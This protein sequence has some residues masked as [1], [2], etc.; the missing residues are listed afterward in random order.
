MLWF[1]LTHVTVRLGK[2][3]CDCCQLPVLLLPLTCD[4]WPIL[5]TSNKG[6]KG[7]NTPGSYSRSPWDVAQG[8][9]SAPG[10]LV[11]QQLQGS[12]GCQACLAATRQQLAGQSVFL[13]PWALACSLTVDVLSL[14]SS[15]Q[16]TVAEERRE[17]EGKCGGCRIRKEQYNSKPCKTRCSE[18]CCSPVT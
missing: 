12:T 1:M 4:S 2:G 9:T 18:L 14:C 15:W 13:Q 5:V 10:A 8:L 17:V 11:C 7:F 3:F 16:T 6:L